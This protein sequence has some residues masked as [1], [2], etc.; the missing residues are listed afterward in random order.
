MTLSMGSVRRHLLF[1]LAGEAAEELQSLRARWDAVMAS[2]T[3]PHVTLVY[4]EETGDEDLLL[5]RA[6]R[7]AADTAPFSIWFDIATGDERGDGGVWFPVVDPSNT[8]DQLRRRI[9]VPPSAPSGVKP[10]ATVV[11]PRTSSRGAEAFS[12]LGGS[13]L[14]G[15]IRIDEIVFTETSKSGMEVLNRFPLAGTPPARMVAGLL[16]RHQMVLLCHR[17]ADRQ[18]FPDCW[19]LP[20]GHVDENEF[21][22]ETLVRELDEELGINVEPPEGPPWRT[23][24]SE[25]LE[26]SVFVVDRWE[27]N[28]R[29][30][31]IDEH[32]AIEWVHADGLAALD[33][34][35]QVYREMLPEALHEIGQAK[36]PGTSRHMSD[37]GGSYTRNDGD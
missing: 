11:H 13:R 24:R 23:F 25:G 5:E 33:Y 15:E 4:P 16:R 26:L 14:P 12:Q 35:D 10:H 1:V 22:A 19:D 34:A 29:N 17:R 6:E 7:A 3:P 2:R 32:D 28:P 27:G 30:I 20:G 36:S 31:A 21:A 18:L 8:W 37:A 9:L